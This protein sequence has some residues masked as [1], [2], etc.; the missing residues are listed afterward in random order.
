MSCPATTGRLSFDEAQ[1]PGLFVDCATKATQFSESPLVKS[2]MVRQVG[3]QHYLT[4][5]RH[6]IHGQLFDVSIHFQANA[7]DRVI[8]VA[9][10]GNEGGSWDDWSMKAEME[11]KALHE[12][13]AVLVFG[14]PLEVMPLFTPNRVLPA[15]VKEDTPRYAQFDWGQLISSY[16]SKGS[17]SVLVLK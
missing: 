17:Q 16:D 5:G 4:L 2:G 8:L 14:K 9:I 12:S 6:V 1:P 11:L 7:I 10:T 15:D 3:D 13:W